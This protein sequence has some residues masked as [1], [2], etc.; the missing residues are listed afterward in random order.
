MIPSHPCKPACRLGFAQL[1]RYPMSQFWSPV[2]HSLTPYVP[3]EQPQLDN[4]IKLNTNEHPWGPSP[5]ALQAIHD[6][7]NDSLRLG[8]DIQAFSGQ[9]ARG[10]ENNQHQ[11][12]GLYYLGAGRSGGYALLNVG[13]EWRA[14]TQLALFMQISNLTDRRYAT[15][16]QLGTTAFDSNGRFVGRPFAEPVIDGERPLLHSTFLAPGAPRSLLLG[17]RLRLDP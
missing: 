4:L 11:P 2:V 7:A 8:A 9:Y 1:R 17:L 15:A 5:K 14:T 3:G 10:N 12:D 16:A 6:A 13:A